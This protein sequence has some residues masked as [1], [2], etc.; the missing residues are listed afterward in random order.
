MDSRRKASVHRVEE[1]GEEA[2]VTRCW[3]KLNFGYVLPRTV[4]PAEGRV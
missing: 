1:A 3:I 4:G 2:P